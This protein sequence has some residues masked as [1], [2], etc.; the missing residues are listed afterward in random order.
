MAI[1]GD[2]LTW[3]TELVCEDCCTCGILFAVPKDFNQI[4]RNNTNHWFYCPNGHPQHYTG[5]TEAQKQKEIAERE[6][7]RRIDA[8][9]ETTRARQDARTNEYRR[10]AEKAKR[11]R[12]EKRIAAGV[13][14]CCNRTFS[15][16]AQHMEQ[17]HPDFPA[18]TEREAG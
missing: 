1:K 17:Q 4:A 6:Y 7:Q 10:R 2:I 18:T 13:C 12:L 16:L 9:R 11:T 15:N 8:E 5:K 14:P 3:S